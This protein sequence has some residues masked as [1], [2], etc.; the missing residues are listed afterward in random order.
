[1]R[2][3][4]PLI[5]AHSRWLA[6]VTV[7]AVSLT[8][9]AAGHAMA[10]SGGSGSGPAPFLSCTSAAACLQWTNNSTGPG[11]EGISAQGRGVMGKTMF[12]STNPS[13]GQAGVAG[14]D[15]S[16]TGTFDAGVFGSSTNGIGVK[17]AS[18]NGVGVK[19]LSNSGYAIV[20]QSASG[21]GG[22]IISGNNIGL[23]VFGGFFESAGPNGPVLSLVQSTAKG[24]G[25]FID[26]C[27]NGGPACRNG[28]SRLVFEVQSDGG[29]FSNGSIF[30]AGLA[31]Q[32]DAVTITTGAASHSG[33][34]V[35]GGGAG[36]SY[37]VISLAEYALGSDFIQMINASST[38]VMRVDDSGNVVITGLIYTAGG[39]SGG[40]AKS[41]DPGN[42]VISYTPRESLPTMEDTGEGRL[43]AGQ[44]YVSIDSSFGGVIDRN[45][46]YVVL[47]TPEADSRGLYVTNKTA[48][49]FAVRENGGGR[50]TMSFGY[51]IVA[52]PYASSAARLPMINMPK[53][54]NAH[55]MA[56]LRRT[57]G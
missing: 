42:H 11:L 15:S 43:V 20:G 4:L 56:A 27:Q 47:I 46:N 52:K 23:N 57:H 13:N 7:A 19:G 50:S 35:A 44:G 21:L 2:F 36:P 53:T 10:G 26:A 25:D 28:D 8:V 30:G 18:T 12:N 39:C 29:L 34:Y 3:R 33:L 37:P 31:N 22:S 41:K 16:S 55:A 40:C 38:D 54:A 5:A 9:A 48:N 14:I 51:R 24:S 17:G 32:F 1:M 45:T 6:V 49:G